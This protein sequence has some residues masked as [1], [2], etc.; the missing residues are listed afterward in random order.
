[1]RTIVVRWKQPYI[2]ADT[3]FSQLLALPLPKHILERTYREDRAN[4]FGVPHWSTEYVGAGPY[5]VREWLPDSHVMLEAFADYALGRPKVQELEV[6]F[7]P[8]PNTLMAN[9]L[10]GSVEV[11]LGRGLDYDQGLQLEERWKTGAIRWSV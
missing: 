9:V 10:A 3:M 5:R 4:F 11:T 7:I 6:K 8:D 1:E 2:E